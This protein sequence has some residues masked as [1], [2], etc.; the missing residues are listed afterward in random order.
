MANHF[1]KID[2]FFLH[3]VNRNVNILG[4]R[5]YSPS[6]KDA[7]WFE[8]A[9]LSFIIFHTFKLAG[10]RRGSLENKIIDKCMGS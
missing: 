1:L 7:A 5:L 4:R 6:L 3:F 2:F 10:A 9:Q 8:D